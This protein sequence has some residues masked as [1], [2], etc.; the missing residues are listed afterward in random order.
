MPL[1]GERVLASQ[2]NNA[3]DP[4]LC[5]AHQTTGQSIPN[6]T[7]TAVTLD[8]E[9]FDTDSMHST[10]VNTSRITCV[11]DGLYEVSGQIPYTANATGTREIRLAKNGVTLIAGG[12]ILFPAPA[13]CVPLPTI[14]V[15]LVAGDYL[16][17]MALQV[18]TAALTLS[19]TNGLFPYLRVKRVSD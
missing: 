11:T 15:Q 18:S 12:R 3:V 13:T 8:T 6:N 9:D 10:S 17:I 16:E 7:Q 2:V 1:A 5:Q 19:A 4:P 14:F